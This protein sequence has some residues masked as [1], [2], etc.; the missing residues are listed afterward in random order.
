MC[1]QLLALLQLTTFSRLRQLNSDAKHMASTIG[2][3]SM[4]GLAVTSVRSKMGYSTTLLGCG[5]AASD[6]VCVGSLL[7]FVLLEHHRGVKSTQHERSY[8]C[9]EH[10]E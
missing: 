5:S 4:G 2:R 6:T 10:T 3:H 1:E 9:S 7:G 8:S